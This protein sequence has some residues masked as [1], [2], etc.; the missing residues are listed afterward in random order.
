MV[1]CV[2]H[3][4]QCAK[5]GH[6]PLP[7]RVIDVSIRDDGRDPAVYLSRGESARYVTL[8]YCWGGD[9]ELVS[10]MSN[11]DELVRGIPTI[12][13]PPT[14]RDAIRVTRELGC[15][16]L[17]VD[18]LCIL[19]DSDED[20]AREIG[21][22]SQIYRNSYCTI[23]AASSPG[24]AH[25]FLEDR[26]Y[27]GT[28]GD[29]FALPYACPDSDIVGRIHVRTEVTYQPQREP[30]NAR[31]WTLQE[32]LLPPR[33]LVYDTYRL[34]WECQSTILS[35]GGA[36]N[37]LRTLDFGRIPESL[38]AK[39][40]ER[41][42]E[43]LSHSWSKEDD[44]TLYRCWNSTIN[45][46]SRRQLSVATDKLPAISA[47]AEQYGTLSGDT[48]IAGLWKR[49]IGSTL[50][51]S[52]QTFDDTKG[53]LT[54]PPFYRAPSWSWASLDYRQIFTG[55]M[56]PWTGDIE[57]VHYDVKPVSLL[58]PYGAVTEGASITLC[59]MTRT[60][61]AL[62]DKGSHSRYHLWD[63][64]GGIQLA[65][66]VPDCYQELPR[67]AAA[68]E[69]HEMLYC[70]AVTRDPIGTDTKSIDGLV[71][72]NSGTDY[73]AR[74]GTFS[75]TSENVHAWLQG[76]NKATVTII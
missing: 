22:M 75:V 23:S 33:I 1:E 72:R 69:T 43:A 57:L 58:V 64:E 34:R 66:Y 59:G 38:R 17:W 30:I 65:Q 36:P 6:T 8:S 29:W 31:G 28:E 4:S 35:D 5:P 53:S 19:Q 14:I 20:K 70:L 13:L 11:I 37:L 61:V 9:Q 54:R 49:H 15:R 16:Y 27:L 76:S 10:T 68:G 18:A 26:P 60:V 63:V 56:T 55:S 39:A 45:V 52:C 62:L 42:T 48:Y 71:L 3:H 44:D 67:Q 40:T 21:M 50:M 24:V 46:Y 47:F 73:Y 51:W 32:H 12:A 25:G 2:T 7:S 74:I 41:E